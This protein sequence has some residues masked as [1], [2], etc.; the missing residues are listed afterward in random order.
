MV[1]SLGWMQRRF[2]IFHQKVRNLPNSIC[3][4]KLYRGRPGASEG[5]LS[6]VRGGASWQG[7]SFDLARE[8]G[9]FSSAAISNASL[10]SKSPAQH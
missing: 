3:L 7:I 8:R 5:R 2:S 10:R 6:N 9:F 4:S 1:W